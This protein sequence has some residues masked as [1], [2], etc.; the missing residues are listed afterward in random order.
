MPAQI[1]PVVRRRPSR[2][3]STCMRYRDL[4]EAIAL[5]NDVPQGLSSSIFTNDL[6]EA[7]RF[8][9]G[10]GSRLRHR[11]RQHRPVRRRDRRRLRRREGDRRRPRVRLRRLE[12]LHAPR[13]Q[14]DQ[15][16]HDAAARPGRQVRHRGVRGG[17]P[18][19]GAGRGEGAFSASLS[20]RRL[21]SDA[22]TGSDAPP[23]PPSSLSQPL[24][25]REKSLGR[26]RPTTSADTPEPPKS[27]SSRRG[28][29][30]Q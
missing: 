4:D 24:G 14:H 13:H 2:R 12:G 18:L 8:L 19:P 1:G 21:L 20:L 10:G 22:Q 11:Q 3:S 16:R 9:V 17:L 5:H 15:F 6:R 25:T 30:A 23:R 28:P 27:R 7:E 29:R 26:F